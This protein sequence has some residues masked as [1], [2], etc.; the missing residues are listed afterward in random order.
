[1]WPLIGK[2]DERARKQV[3]AQDPDATADAEG[4]RSNH[5]ADTLSFAQ[6]EGIASSR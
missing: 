4:A 5:L 1:M 3:E 2:R 6:A